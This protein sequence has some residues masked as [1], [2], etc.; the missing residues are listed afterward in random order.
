MGRPC[1]GTEIKIAED[2]EILVK[3]PQIFAKNR[4]Y[5]NRAELNKEAFTEDGYFKTGDI[6]HFD[7]DGY[8][9]ITDRKKELLVTAGGKNVAP[10]PIEMTLALDTYIEHACVIGDAKK[11]IGAL[12]VPQFELLEKWAKKNGIAFASQQDLVANPEVK[13][14]YQEKVDKV[15]EKLARYEQIKKFVL[16]PVSF[17]EQG[18]EL[19]PTQKLKRRNVYKRFTGEIES[20]Y[21]D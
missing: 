15:N 14:F 8:L 7:E 1:K 4:G 6:G 16:L 10:H 18:G 21:R 19:T 9:I 12:I 17:T 20:L 3:G 2:G 5:L 13:K 11:F